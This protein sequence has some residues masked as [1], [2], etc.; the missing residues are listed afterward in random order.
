MFSVITQKVEEAVEALGLDKSFGD[1]TASN[2]PDLS[3][4]QCNGPMRA[5]G[6]LGRAPRDIANDLKGKLDK[7]DIF[8]RVTVDGPGFINLTLSDEFIL[9][10][11]AGSAMNLPINQAPEKII[12]D[13]GGPNVAKPLH[14]GHLRSAIIGE[15]IKRIARELGHEVIAD[16]HLGDWGTPMGMLIAKLKDDHPEWPCF[17]DHPTYSETEDAPNISTEDLNLLYPRAAQQFKNDEAF[18]Q[19]AREATAQ[20][21]AGHPGYRQ[22]WR[23]FVDLSVASIKKDFD[24]I[25]VSFDLWM[26][27]S[28]AHT[29]SQKL[30]EDLLDAGV[31]KE[32]QGA[33]VI[34]VANT[35]DRIDVP[36]LMLQKTDGSAS[37][38]TTDLATIFL[39][40]RDYS[41]DRI[42]YV[43]DQRQSLHFTQVFRAADKAGYINESALEH[44]GFGTM[45]GK[46]G[47]PFKTRAGGVM[48][49]GDLIRNAV[50]RATHEAGFEGEQTDEE[51]KKMIASIAVA[52][53][54]FGDLC[55]VRTTDYIFDLDE[56]VRFDGKTGPYVQYAAV[57][58]RSVLA[59]T[60]AEQPMSTPQTR[61]FTHKSERALAL[62]LMNFPS[63]LQKAFDKRMPSD[64]CEYSY[65][66]ATK[67]SAFYHEC[68]VL[69]EKNPESRE[70]RLYLTQKAQSTLNNALR[71]L[72]IPVPKKMVRAHKV[73]APTP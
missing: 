12:I 21:Q 25:G 40:T 17:S 14:V 45:N 47:K 49:L 58:A 37:Y 42:L 5:A 53:I 44:V 39:R 67:F 69:T 29:T 72:D 4:M 10:A 71:C 26:G 24:A 35:D 55:N 2:R 63:V 65:E 57:R 33:I 18:A 16:I 60:G 64:L 46:D 43:V 48:R 7:S 56:F 34:D 3:D 28:H 50:D 73:H 68:P 62:S 22:L 30:V 59:K 15:A 38:A 54:K 61:T 66:L 11:F 13:Y 19:K 51:T 32:S 27:E 36:P 20:L 70:L 8:S 41:P 6:V 31:A 52:A 23:R 1:V 9:R